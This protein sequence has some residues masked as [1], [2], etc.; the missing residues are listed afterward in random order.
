MPKMFDQWC[1]RSPHYN[2]SHREWADTVK[3]F[4]AREIEPH[5]DAW[6]RAG[7]L[8]RELHRKAAEVGLMNV[9]RSQELQLEQT[10]SDSLPAR[11]V[12][13]ARALEEASP[14]ALDDDEDVQRYVQMHEDALDS[15]IK[16]FLLP[17]STLQQIAN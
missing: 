17:W 3:R 9:A 11:G 12:T 10:W 8:P 13:S 1:A 14:G 6:E 16:S 15:P 2:D 7:E 5:I 4:V